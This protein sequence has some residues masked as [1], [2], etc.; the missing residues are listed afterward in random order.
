ME[1]DFIVALGWN[2]PLPINHQLHI[3]CELELPII[4]ELYLPMIVHVTVSQ[5]YSYSCSKFNYF[6]FIEIFNFGRFCKFS[7]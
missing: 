7:M 6:N 4:Y 3:N 2:G 1:N 5:W